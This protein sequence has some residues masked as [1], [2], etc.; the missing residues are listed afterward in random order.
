VRG[1]L[2]VIVFLSLLVYG[3]WNGLL[4]VQQYMNVASLVDET[5]ERELPAVSGTGWHPTD[6]AARLRE[7][8]VESARQAG[9]PVDA[10]G[11]LVSE[12]SNVLAVRVTS[13]YTLARY[14]DKAL[15]FPISTT[16][17]FPVPPGNR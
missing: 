3:G 12:D 11:V 13:T 5:V 7:S 6:R 17:S 16:R 1:F 9:L 4:A 2:P 10:N 14:E 15:A 8:I